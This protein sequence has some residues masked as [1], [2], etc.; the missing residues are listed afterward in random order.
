MIEDRKHY[1]ILLEAKVEG[2]SY[3]K[4]RAWVDSEYLLPSKEELYAKSG[5]ILKSVKIVD[6]KKINDRWAPTHLIF[7]DELKR[8][9][10]GTEWIVEDIQYDVDI[11][12]TRF[13]KA[14]LR[15]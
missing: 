3:P 1:V 8:N 5:K 15:K 14:L 6:F 7:K 12:D 11:P 2:L 4:R 10:Q 9:S 13:T